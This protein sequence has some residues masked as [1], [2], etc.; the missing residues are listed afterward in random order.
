LH[1]SHINAL[2][3]TALLYILPAE[4]MELA[5]HWRT[6]RISVSRV[7]EHMNDNTGLRQRRKQQPG[8][9]LHYNE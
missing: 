3:S 4:V 5:E 2:L 7:R 6:I 9:T 1:T 8:S